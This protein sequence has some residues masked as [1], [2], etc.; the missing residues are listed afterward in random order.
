ML[1]SLQIHYKN[2]TQT[3]LQFKCANTLQKTVLEITD[4]ELKYT[5]STSVYPKKLL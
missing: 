1:C 3:P 4:L 5:F 2:G